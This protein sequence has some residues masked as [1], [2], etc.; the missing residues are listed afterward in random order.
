MTIENINQ[1]EQSIMDLIQSIKDNNFDPKH[2]GKEQRLQCVEALICEGITE[3]MISKLLKVS[4]KT[5]SRDLHIIRERNAISPNIDFAKQIV[6]E[7][8]QKARVHHGYLMRLARSKES[9]ISE[10]TQAEFFAWRVFNEMMER[11]QSLGYLP[12]RPQG[13]VGDLYHHM[14]ESQEKT[15]DEI[16]T[17]L[18]EAEAVAIE[19]GGLSP[20]MQKEINDIRAKIEKVEIAYQAEVLSKKQQICQK[21]GEVQNENVI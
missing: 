20:D 4:T 9:E 16:K 15:Y 18:N 5:I 1:E 7:L 11:L 19:T 3:S 10:K 14:G 6:G 17:M 12:L 21:E 13:I 8:L 2:L